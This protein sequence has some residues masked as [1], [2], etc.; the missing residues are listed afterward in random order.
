MPR[1]PNYASGCV[2]WSR[3]ADEHAVATVDLSCVS[4][5]ESSRSS[6]R[7]NCVEVAAVGYAVAARD[8]Q[9]PDGGTL[10]ISGDRWISFLDRVRDGRF[11]VS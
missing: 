7:A 6:K 8:S 1:S 10:V 5:R 2:R 9:C 4:W 11:D 3:F